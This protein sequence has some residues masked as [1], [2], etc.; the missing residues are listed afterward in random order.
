M[1]MHLKTQKSVHTLW[2]RQCP[3]SNLS[4]RKNQQEKAVW[5]MLF[6]FCIIIKIDNKLNAHQKGTIQK[7]MMIMKP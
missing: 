6:Q 3:P 1:T 2:A 4:Q 5:S 7:N